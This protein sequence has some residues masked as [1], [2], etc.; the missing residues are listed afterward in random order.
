MGVTLK[1]A[2]LTIPVSDFQQSIEWY[3]KHFGFKV[4][5]KDPFYVE[6]QND[7]GIR[8]LLQQNVHNLHSHFVYPDGALQSSYGFIVDDAES[9]YQYLLSN[10]VKVGEF[11]NYQGKSF[12]F[13]D[14]DGNFIEIWSL[15]ETK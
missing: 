3:G 7:L 1:T 5:T 12:S 10:G 13:Y 15:P 11:F 9:V 2:Y 6:L 14:P 4:V 8:I